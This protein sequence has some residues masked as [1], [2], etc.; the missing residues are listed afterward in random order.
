MILLSREM[1][2]LL[3]RQYG[4]QLHRQTFVMDKGESNRSLPISRSGSLNRAEDT[5]NKHSCARF[6]PPFTKENRLAKGNY[7]SR[8]LIFRRPSRSHRRALSTLNSGGLSNLFWVPSSRPDLFR[9]R[10]D[11]IQWPKQTSP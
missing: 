1:V 4:T 2:G 9:L 11:S 5:C 3:K 10:L 8:G 7:L 6:A